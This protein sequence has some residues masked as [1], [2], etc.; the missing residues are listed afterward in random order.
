M[1]SSF[2]LY[3][4][5]CG[6]ANQAQA[7]FCFACGHSLQVPVASSITISSSATGLLVPTHL[8]K[9]RYRI[10]EQLGR[11]GMGAVYKAEDTLFGNQL[12]AVKE[13]SQN[14]LNGQ[15]IIEV[16]EAFNR[17]AHLLAGLNHPNFPKI[18]DHFSDAGRWYLVMDF[19][20]GETLET[21][22]NKAKG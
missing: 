9:E 21:Y 15:E 20:A 13:M 2:S 5:N 6:A 7:A 16:T 12:V 8:L 18:H 19:I 10:V 11:G 4:T 22:L 17:E 3:C 14:G 1:V